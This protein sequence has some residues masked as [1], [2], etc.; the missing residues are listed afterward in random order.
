[1]NKP[2]F[3]NKKF[4]ATGETKKVLGITLH[5]IRLVDDIAA[6]GLAAGTLGGWIQEGQNLS[7]YDDA[8][9]FDGAQV[10]DGARVSGEAHVYGNAQVSGNAW[11]Y[12]KAH[13]YGNAQVFGGARVSGDAWV[14]GFNIVATRSDSCTFLVAPTPDGPRIIAGC[15]YFTFEE[16]EQHWE[17]TRG[18]TQLGDESLAIVK[19]L[20]AM[21]K[22]NGFME[23][24]A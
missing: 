6:L 5:R 20:K 2:A 10:F 1:M 23:P 19:H 11:A 9:V 3:K 24:V 8:W 21:A 13:V 4:E 22:I 18:G 15:R 12:G 17:K 7:V 14:S 16:A